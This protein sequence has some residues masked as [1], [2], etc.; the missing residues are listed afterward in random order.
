MNVAPTL[1]DKADIVQNA[2]DLAHALGIELP[3]V[4]I[5]S[6]METVNP[7]FASTLDA[8]AL[9]KMVE[10]KQITGGP[11]D[12]PL[13]F[14]SAVSPKAAAARGMSSA[15]ARAG[16]YPGA[17]DIESAVMLVKQLNIWRTP[18]GRAWWSAP[19]C[20]SC[21]PAAPMGRCHT[22]HPARWRSCWRTIERAGPERRT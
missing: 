4:A 15:G 3:K 18:R 21:P 17:P 20:P 16:R 9:C 13:A 1:E 14:D 10:R 2:I 19:G 5:L 8:A 6:A 11:L 12:G 7:E 22:W